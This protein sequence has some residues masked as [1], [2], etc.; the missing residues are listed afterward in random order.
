MFFNTITPLFMR[1]KAQ[2]RRNIDLKQTNILHFL[3]KKIAFFAPRKQS[4]NQKQQ[5]YTL[6]NQKKRRYQNL[7][8]SYYNTP[9]NKH[10]NIYYFFLVRAVFFLAV[11]FDLLASSAIIA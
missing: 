6:K 7:Y 9:Q 4:S 3:P 1:Q 2:K 10:I 8:K 5:F 11:P